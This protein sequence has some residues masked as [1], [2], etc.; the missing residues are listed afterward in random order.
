M[1]DKATTEYSS[2]LPFCDIGKWCPGLWSDIVIW[3]ERM[4]IGF[5]ASEQSEKET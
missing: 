5:T 4:R 1:H 2:I 3:T